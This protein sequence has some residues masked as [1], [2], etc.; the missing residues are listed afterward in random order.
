MWEVRWLM[1]ISTALAHDIHEQIL[2]HKR[3]LF[4]VGHTPGSGLIL[5]DE[6]RSAF[7]PPLT[8]STVLRKEDL[9]MSSFTPIFGTFTEEDIVAIERDRER[10]SKRKKRATRARRGIVLPDREP[11]KT[12]RS[13]VN[14]IGPDG[15]VPPPAEPALVAAPTT[16]RRAAAIAAQANINLLAQ[17]LPIPQPPSPVQIPTPVNRPRRGPQPR[18]NRGVSRE[19]SFFNGDANTPLVIG[20]K[21]ALREDSA[22]DTITLHSPLPPSKRRNNGKV[23]DSP[24]ANNRDDSVPVKMEASGGGVGGW[25][26]KNCGTP[27][28]FSGGQKRD[29]KNG[30]KTLCATCG[31]CHDMCGTILN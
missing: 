3:S 24:E 21:R 16:S 30:L 15:L 2:V 26:C 14:P 1:G 18:S 12:H 17:D 7:L 4:L 23:F 29:P 28:H 9:A 22:T 13:L 11:L 10:D 19:D 5:D 20:V 8:N 27:E 31:K 6:V 25:R